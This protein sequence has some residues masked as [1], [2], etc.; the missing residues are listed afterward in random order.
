MRKEVEKVIK[1]IIES[2][3]LCKQCDGAGCVMCEMKGYIVN[4]E[5]LI[6]G[7]K[8]WESPSLSS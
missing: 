5:N 1:Q 7:L 6:D 3:K 4:R 2:L 8:K